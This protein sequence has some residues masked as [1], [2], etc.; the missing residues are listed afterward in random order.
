MTRIVKLTQS[1]RSL[2]C[3]KDVMATSFH[4]V[5]EVAFGYLNDKTAGLSLKE[6]PA[7]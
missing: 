4:L 5:D 2:I 6:Q 7:A 3:S 1:G